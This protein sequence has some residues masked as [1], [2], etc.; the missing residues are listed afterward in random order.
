MK[1]MNK[2]KHLLVIFPLLIFMVGCTKKDNNVAS[3]QMQLKNLHNYYASV[4]VDED[5]KITFAVTDPSSTIEEKTITLES[6][7]LYLSYPAYTKTI[8]GDSISFP[9]TF[10]FAA[11]GTYPMNVTLASPSRNPQVFSFN[12]IVEPSCESGLPGT[13]AAYDSASISMFP[14]HYSAYVFGTGE[15]NKLNI[16][17]IGKS[18]KT[19]L[20]C[21]YGT[22]TT[23]QY[24]NSSSV[25]PVGT[26][27]FTN[28]KIILKYT[29]K[30]PP[31]PDINVTTTLTR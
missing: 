11:A 18:L 3:N 24:D 5:F 27:T 7:S 13:W 12:I 14:S 28:N 2:L 10:N 15:A 8:T 29:I 17:L 31:S 4:G 16:E 21:H 20:A 6:A 1:P 22:L 19:H 30:S 23:E 26:G 25:I 9:F